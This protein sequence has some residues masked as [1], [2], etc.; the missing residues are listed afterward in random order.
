MQN[1]GELER[2]A[3]RFLDE[4]EKKLL[5]EEAYRD[6][7]A[8]LIVPIHPEIY[9]DTVKALEAI[10]EL[11]KSRKIRVEQVNGKRLYELKFIRLHEE[12]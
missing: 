5:Y 2:I 10:N 6:I 7:S 1:R 4:V 11:G 9:A 8:G 12:M 3:R